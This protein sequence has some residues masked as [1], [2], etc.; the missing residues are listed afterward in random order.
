MEKESNNQQRIE[1][2]NNKKVREI[3]DQ[4]RIKE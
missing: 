4:P 2:I 3:N 1:K